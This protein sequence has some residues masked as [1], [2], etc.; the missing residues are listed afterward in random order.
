[1]KEKL[2]P[3]YVNLFLVTEKGICLKSPD[4]KHQLVSF[5]ADALL[6]FKRKYLSD[7]PIPLCG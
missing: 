2:T 3:T 6:R 5:N 4:G 7:I 1:M